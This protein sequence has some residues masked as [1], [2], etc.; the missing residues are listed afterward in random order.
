MS[1]AVEFFLFIFIINRSLT[2][3]SKLDVNKVHN[4]VDKD[5]LKKKQ[6]FVVEI[7]D[8]V[9]GGGTRWVDSKV[10]R[11]RALKKNENVTRIQN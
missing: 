11:H 8:I 1:L 2:A 9:R 7:V 3:K 10:R 6:N 5:Y 4:C